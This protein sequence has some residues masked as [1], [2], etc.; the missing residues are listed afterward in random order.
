M[1]KISFVWSSFEMFVQFVKSIRLKNWIN[2]IWKSSISFCFFFSFVDYYRCFSF[3][4]HKKNRWLRIFESPFFDD[5]RD[6]I[7]IF[8]TLNELWSLWNSMLRLCIKLSICGFESSTSILCVYGLY[9]TPNGRGIVFAY[10]LW[11][12]H[13]YKNKLSI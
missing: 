2:Y 11:I 1:Y 13:W 12:C 9:R 8:N 7:Y 6:T 10:F 3:F 4:S 5:S